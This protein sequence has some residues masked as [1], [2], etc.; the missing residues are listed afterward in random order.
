[1]TLF[2]SKSGSVTTT[3][4]LTLSLLVST[5]SLWT[6]LMCLVQ[7]SLSE[8]VL[9]HRLHLYG[10]TPVWVFQCLLQEINISRHSQQLR[11]YLSSH[12]WLNDMLHISH[13]KA[14]FSLSVSPSS[15]ILH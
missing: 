4:V 11:S 5:W 10:F 3:R 12:F 15:A 9:K 7:L 14:L 2:G 13:G 8:K 1:M 6:V